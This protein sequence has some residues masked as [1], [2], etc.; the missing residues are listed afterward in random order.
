M[1]IRKFY[2]SYT[3]ICPIR[4]TKSIFWK[5]E[6]RQTI[7]GYGDSECNSRMLGEGSYRFSLDP[8]KHLGGGGGGE[9]N[10]LGGAKQVIGLFLI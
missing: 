8:G 7:E 10:E 6:N 1:T 3:L 5:A 2:C 4:K 9:Q